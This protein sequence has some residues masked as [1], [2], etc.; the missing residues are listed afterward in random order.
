MSSRRPSIRIRG[1]A[2]PHSQRPVPHA[3]EIGRPVAQQGGGLAAQV[4]PDEFALG[5]G[6]G[7]A[8][9]PVG[10]DDRLAALRIHDLE[11]RVAARRQVQA[12]AGVALAGHRRPHVAHAERVAHRGL[13]Q[14]LDPRPD[15]ARA[16]SGLAGRDDV[17]QPEVLDRIQAG[18]ASALGQVDG[19][20]ERAEQRVDAELGHELEQPRR[21]AD[22]DRHDGRPARLERHVVSDPAGVERVVEAVRDR[23]LAPDAGDR[24]RVAPDAR[25]RRVVA[26]R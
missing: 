2:R 18:L 14:R 13:P 15:A 3:A 8:G 22:A 11:H 6:G 25:V 26:G 23:V 10:V 19:V 7:H 24:E 17:E 20:G 4:G 1:V 12:P 16:G 21:L 5:V 9:G